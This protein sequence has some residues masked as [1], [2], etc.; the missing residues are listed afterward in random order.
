VLAY[1]HVPNEK[2]IET[3]HNKLAG[4]EAANETSLYRIKKIRSTNVNIVHDRL[5]NTIGQAIVTTSLP[6]AWR[7]HQYLQ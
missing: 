4:N 2:Q 1:I 6:P 7:V 3:H 5:D